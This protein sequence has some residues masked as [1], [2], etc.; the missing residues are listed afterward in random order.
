VASVK[1]F[2]NSVFRGITKLEERGLLKTRVLEFIRTIYFEDVCHRI[3]GF[4][5]PEV[6]RIHGAG[7]AMVPRDLKARASLDYLLESGHVED[8]YLFH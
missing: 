3:K 1:P 2:T 6:Q 8:I 4:G 7:S 5:E